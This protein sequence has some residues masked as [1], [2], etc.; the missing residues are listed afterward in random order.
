V[1]ASKPIASASHLAFFGGDEPNYA[2]MKDGQKLMADYGKPGPRT[3]V[4]RRTI[5]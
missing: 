3:L 1:D 4:F 2:T 5:C